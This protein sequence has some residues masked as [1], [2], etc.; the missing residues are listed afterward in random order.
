MR[1][2]ITNKTI[3]NLTILGKVLS[4][5]ER[6][7]I[8][9]NLWTKIIRNDEIIPLVEIGSLQ[10]DDG[11]SVLTGTTAIDWINNLYDITEVLTR[12]S[13]NYQ[14][15][16]TKNGNNLMT[17]ATW[18]DVWPSSTSSGSYSGFGSS[19]QPIII[20]YNCRLSN[21]LISFRRAYFDWRSS[22]GNIFI[23]LGFYT[24]LYNQATDYCRLGMELIGSFSGG[25][26]NYN[27]YKFDI[28]EFTA[29]VGNNSFTK[30]SLLGVQLRKDI[31]QQGQ[32]QSLSDPILLLTFE[33]SI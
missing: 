22:P 3:N 10:V 29:R 8:L 18:F 30:N 9:P 5:E 32:I 6:W 16:K 26:S 2:Y 28:S 31:S 24:H 12:R 13:F 17:N 7:E 1:K 15:H 4:P 14:I 11:S 21:V 19:T 20:P 27:T 25:Y 23:E 33:E